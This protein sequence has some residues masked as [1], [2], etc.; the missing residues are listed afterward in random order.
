MG[1]QLP[2]IGDVSD[3]CNDSGFQWEFRCKKCG[4]GHR[5]PFEHNMAGEGRGLLRMASSL[6]G[7]KVSQA[8]WGLDAYNSGRGGGGSG[9][10]DRH[11]AKAVQAVLP[12]FRSCPKCTRW[13]CAQLCWNEPAGHCL[14]CL[15][16]DRTAPPSGRVTARC[17]TCGEVGNGKFCESCG[18]ERDAPLDCP[19]CGVAANPGAAFCSG[20]GGKLGAAKG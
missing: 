18:A 2:V 7:G 11:Y 1:E 6:F 4:N 10:R 8:S 12:S 19:T 9:R 15:P 17:T 5:S 3:L 16:A 20:C 13:V 14:E